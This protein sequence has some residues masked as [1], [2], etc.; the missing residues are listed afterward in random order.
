MSCAVYRCS[1]TLS[2]L[3]VAAISYVT[4]YDRDVDETWRVRKAQGIHQFSASY[5]CKFAV[6]LTLHTVFLIY[7]TNKPVEYVY[8]VSTYAQV[9]SVNLY[10]ITPIC[11]GVTYTICREFTSCVLLK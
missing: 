11:F 8:Y 10:E 7:I 1:P 9:S 3:H 5:N 2:K 6:S 4:S